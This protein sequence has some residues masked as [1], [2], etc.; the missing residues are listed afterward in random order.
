MEDDEVD[1]SDLSDF[2]GEV[3]GVK[4]VPLAPTKNGGGGSDHTEQVNYLILVLT[5]Q[6]QEFG[7]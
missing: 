5:E 7:E 6:R 1:E 4:T 3:H 2:G